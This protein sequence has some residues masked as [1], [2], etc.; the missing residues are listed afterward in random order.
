M[1]K[2]LKAQDLFNVAVA[3]LAKQGFK[4]ARDRYGNLTYVAPDGCR[5]AF[6]H[7]LPNKPVRTFYQS[8]A[9]SPYY[10]GLPT[11]LK[12]DM[13]DRSGR[14]LSQLEAAHNDGETPAEMKLALRN[15]AK[16]FKLKT[17]KELR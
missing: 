7:I 15:V 3:G 4:Q 5:C 6:G 12:I 8:F 16:N 1:G 14:F 2:Q 9:V 13:Q 17:P 11:F 10:Y